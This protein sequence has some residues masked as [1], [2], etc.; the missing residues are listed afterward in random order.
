MLQEIGRASTSAGRSSGL[1]GKAQ[2]A[3]VGTIS[4]GDIVNRPIARPGEVLEA[5]P[6]VIVTQHSGEGKANQYY[7]RG[8]QLDH[9]TDLSATI[10]GE[11]INFPTHAHG[12]GY[13]D[14]NWLLPEMVSFV[15]FKKGPY[16][17]DEG[18]FSPAGSYNLFYRN[19]IPNT[20]ELSGGS[21]GFGRIFLAGS[22]SAGT[23]HFLYALEAYHDDGT[24]DRPD[25]YRRFNGVLRYSRATD[26]EDFNVT[27]LGYSGIFDSSDQISQRLVDAG[28]ARERGFGWRYRGSTGVHGRVAFPLLRAAHPHRGRLGANAADGTRERAVRGKAFAQIAPDVRRLQP[29]RRQ[30]R[31]YDVF[32]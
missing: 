17:A 2:S 3:S 25:N 18:D 20:V 30:R 31:R 24:F 29:A 8:F 28:V 13:S 22:P 10:V 32:L 16:Y 9:G 19:T 15:E 5:I 26:K 27:A 12:Q 21:N 14:I 4:Q 11:P 23:G 6:G 7:L 1:I